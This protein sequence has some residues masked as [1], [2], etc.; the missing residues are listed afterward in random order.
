MDTLKAVIYIFTVMICVNAVAAMTTHIGI[1][2]NVAMDMDQAN[3]IVADPRNTD[4]N[5]ELIRAREL[6]RGL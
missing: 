1:T 3:R 2:N 6:V 4:K 5:D